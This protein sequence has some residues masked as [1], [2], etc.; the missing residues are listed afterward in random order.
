MLGFKE[1][2]SDFLYFGEVPLLLAQ[3]A[4]GARLEPALYAVL[5]EHVAAGAPR[6]AETRVVRVSCAPQPAAL[7]TASE[8]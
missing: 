8:P 1:P 2:H 4:V 6:D 5:V 3:R 7:S